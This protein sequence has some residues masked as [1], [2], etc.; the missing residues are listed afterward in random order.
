MQELE[1]ECVSDLVGFMRMEPG[2]FQELLLRVATRITVAQQSCDRGTTRWLVVK[3]I[4]NCK[5]VLLEIGAEY[6]K[7]EDDGWSFLALACSKGY[8][9][10]VKMLLEIGAEYNKYE[11]DGW[12]LLAL[13]CSKGYPEIVRM[14]LEIGAEYNKYEDDGWSLLALACRKDIQKL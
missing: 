3:D 2:M 10:I 12:S 14:L 1:R 7:Y 13:A 9:E 4:Q 6:N 8:P 5:N 11:D